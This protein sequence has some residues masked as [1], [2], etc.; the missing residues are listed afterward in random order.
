MQELGTY[1]K[2]AVEQGYRFECPCGEYSRTIDNARSCRKCLKY[3]IVPGCY[4][5]DI[6]T[7][8]VVFGTMPTEEEKRRAKFCDWRTIQKA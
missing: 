2:M 8:E 4:V 3:S 7:G 1:Q 6:S 5:I